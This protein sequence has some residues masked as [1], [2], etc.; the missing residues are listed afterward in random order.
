MELLR[1]WDSTDKVLKI[2]DAKEWGKEGHKKNGVLAKGEQSAQY[3]EHE[4][5][6]IVYSWERV[7]GVGL[8]ASWFEK[9]PWMLMKKQIREKS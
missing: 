9:N 6:E 7:F 8:G 1:V 2:R 3:L 4:N 5:L